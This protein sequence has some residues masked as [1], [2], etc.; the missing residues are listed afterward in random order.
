MWANSKGE[1]LQSSF[2]LHACFNAAANYVN[3][4]TSGTFSKTGMYNRSYHDTHWL[5][6]LKEFKKNQRNFRKKAITIK[7]QT[8]Y[9]YA[10]EQLNK[11]IIILC[12]KYLDS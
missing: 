9:S 4:W 6:F 12:S 3:S 7:I 8:K 11:Y 5:N 2:Q 1:Y 10:N